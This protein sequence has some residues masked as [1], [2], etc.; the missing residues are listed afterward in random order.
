VIWV[1]LVLAVG[2]DVA[3]VLALL[4]AR[5]VELELRD[6]AERLDLLERRRR[7]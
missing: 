4:V 1:A 6:F 3:G 5:G 2:A 7:S